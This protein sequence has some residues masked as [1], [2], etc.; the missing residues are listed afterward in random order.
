MGKKKKAEA[1]VYKREDA[2]REPMLIPLDKL[3][4]RHGDYGF[5]EEDD[6]D[7]DYESIQDLA[8]KIDAEGLHDPIW[9]KR[10][11]DLFVI[12][13]GNRRKAAYDRLHRDFGKKYPADYEVRCEVFIDEATEAEILL[14]KMSRDV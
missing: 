9:V 11:G 10:E 12:I 5:R 6:Y 3:V 13:D 1:E 7:L 8:T 4:V 14:R 2:P